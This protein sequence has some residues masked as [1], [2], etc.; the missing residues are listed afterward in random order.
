MVF[1]GRAS[2]GATCGGAFVANVP[3]ATMEGMMGGPLPRLR[4]DI[5]CDDGWT[6][7]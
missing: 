4:I 7:G 1:T 6:Q 2:E 3:A 5:A